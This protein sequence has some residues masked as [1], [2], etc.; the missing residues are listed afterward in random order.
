[1]REIGAYTYLTRGRTTQVREQEHKHSV[2]VQEEQA[3]QDKCELILKTLAPLEK[4]SEK[5]AVL[6]Q[7]FSA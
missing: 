6:A 4:E 2:L 5:L 3:E 7:G 1:M